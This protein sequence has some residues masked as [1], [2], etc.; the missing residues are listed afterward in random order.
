MY[1]WLRKM[2]RL[3]LKFGWIVIIACFAVI[4]GS[5]VLI[6]NGNPIKE[7]EIGK[8]LEVDLER[9]YKT[10]F[11]L[12]YTRYDATRGQFFILTNRIRRMMSRSMQRIIMIMNCTIHIGKKFGHVIFVRQSLTKQ[13]RCTVTILLGSK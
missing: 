6:M 7:K 5:F 12:E 2:R 9:E 4:V 10:K 13:K 11:D 1:W 3:W 8:R